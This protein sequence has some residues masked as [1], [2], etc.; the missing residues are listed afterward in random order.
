MSEIKIPKF[1]ED[2]ANYLVAIRNLSQVYIKNMTV[3]IEQFLEFIN[4]HKFKNKYK[5]FEI[6]IY[7]Y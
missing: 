1:V 3:T 4:V 7:F 2:F 5:K 6:S